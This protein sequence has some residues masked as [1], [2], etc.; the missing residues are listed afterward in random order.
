M[1]T[2]RY[3]YARWLNGQVELFDLKND[4]LQMTNMADLPSA[5]GLRHQLENK[6]QELMNARNDQLVPCTS[7]R[8]WFDNYRRIVRN[9]YGALR[10]PEDEPDW[11]LLV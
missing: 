3:A 5:A 2:K 7:Y 4:P 11:S 8:N 9:V 10:N 1:R 6:R